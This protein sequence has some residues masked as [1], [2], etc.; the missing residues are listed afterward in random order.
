MVYSVLDSTSTYL[1]QFSH[2]HFSGPLY[3][4]LQS[5]AFTKHISPPFPGHLFIPRRFA[6]HHKS[7]SFNKQ[8][9]LT[10]SSGR[11]RAILLSLLSLLL[12][13][14]TVGR[15]GFRGT[16]KSSVSCCEKRT[17]GIGSLSKKQVVLQL[18]DSRF[19]GIGIFLSMPR[20]RTPTNTMT[21]SLKTIWQVTWDPPSFCLDFWKPLLDTFGTFPKNDRKYPTIPRRKPC[22][23][24]RRMGRCK[25]AGRPWSRHIEFRLIH[26]CGPFLKF[27]SNKFVAVFFAG[28]VIDNVWVSSNWFWFNVDFVSEFSLRQTSF[29]DMICSTSP[30]GKDLEIF[31]LVLA[32][33]LQWGGMIRGSFNCKTSNTKYVSCNN[34]Y[35]KPHIHHKIMPF[36]RLDLFMGS[37]HL[38]LL[39]SSQSSIF[40]PHQCPWFPVLSYLRLLRRSSWFFK[41]RNRMKIVVVWRLLFISLNRTLE[42]QLTHTLASTRALARIEQWTNISPSVPWNKPVF[43][44]YESIIKYPFHLSIF[45]LYSLQSTLNFDLFVIYPKSKRFTA[46]TNVPCCHLTQHPSRMV[47]RKGHPLWASLLRPKIL[48]VN[49]FPES[50]Y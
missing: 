36:E 14:F 27:H 35:N 49:P 30:A 37:I 8:T 2:E 19:H 45:K 10:W 11:P 21:L 16:N 38:T 41:G 33:L 42:K 23:Q 47:K 24:K 26:R 43:W 28:I 48:E 1:H 20:F 25:A 3:F 44:I 46:D 22:T 4:R 12:V 6:S 7:P 50:K 32:D 15:R 39:V 18:G 31:S 40:S 9:P 29:N 17:L 34:L 5:L 13:T